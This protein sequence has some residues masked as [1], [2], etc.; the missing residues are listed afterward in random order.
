MEFLIFNN[1]EKQ[2]MET[3]LK[4]LACN[5]SYNLNERKPTIISC[6]HTICNECFKK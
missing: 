5:K 1:F 4:C 2:N 3:L 6:G